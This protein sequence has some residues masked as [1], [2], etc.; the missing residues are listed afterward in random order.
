MGQRADRR[1]REEKRRGRCPQRRPSRSCLPKLMTLSTCWA[2]RQAL[3][4]R[5]V[6]RA[7]DTVCMLLRAITKAQYMYAHTCLKVIE[8]DPTKT[9]CLQQAMRVFIALI[10][11]NCRFHRHPLLDGLIMLKRG[12]I[13]DTLTQLEVSLTLLSRAVEPGEDVL[14]EAAVLLNCQLTLLKR[15]AAGIQLPE[16]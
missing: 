1:A 4:A 9:P 10:T 11:H 16:E 8:A 6:W 5:C 7:S 12:V 3:R 15:T 13:L 14:Y 2:A